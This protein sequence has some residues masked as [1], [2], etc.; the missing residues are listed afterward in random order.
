M[1]RD[2]AASSALEPT[3]LVEGPQSITYTHDTTVTNPCVLIIEINRWLTL[4]D[5]STPHSNPV[6]LTYRE[7]VNI[8]SL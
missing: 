1:I 3:T 8:S 4:S 5:M 7:T 2:G 6:N